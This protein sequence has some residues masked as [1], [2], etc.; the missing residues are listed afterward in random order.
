MFVL[1]LFDFFCL[2]SFRLSDSFDVVRRPNGGGSGLRSFV[3]AGSTQSKAGPSNTA[4]ETLRYE[5]GGGVSKAR[6]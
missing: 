4:R 6:S 2:S 3:P 1:G 5:P